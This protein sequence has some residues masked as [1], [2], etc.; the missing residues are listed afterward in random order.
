MPRLSKVDMQATWGEAFGEEALL[1]HVSML[2]IFLLGHSIR[3]TS[4]P[5]NSVGF[6][7][8]GLPLLVPLTIKLVCGSSS[9][10]ARHT[11]TYHA[12]RDTTRA[13]SAL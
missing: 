11:D 10:H 2:R 7:L 12:R 5:C 8:I 6:C 1:G 4:F 3:C 9:R 13:N